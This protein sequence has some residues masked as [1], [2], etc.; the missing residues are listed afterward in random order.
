MGSQGKLLVPNQRLIS[1]YREECL[2][3]GETSTGTSAGGGKPKLWSLNCWMLSMVAQPVGAV[4]IGE[5]FPHASGGG[6]DGTRNHFAILNIPKHSVLNKVSHQEKPTKQSL[7]C[8]DFIRPWAGGRKIHNSSL[9]QPSCPTKV[10]GWLRSTYEVQKITI[11][12][13]KVH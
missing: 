5:K 6:W 12:S 1:K 2:C 8:W 3:G 7:N 9:L 4:K 13:Y 11:Q 10:G